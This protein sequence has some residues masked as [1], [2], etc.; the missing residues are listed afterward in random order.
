MDNKKQIARPSNILDMVEHELQLFNL[1]TKKRTREYAQARF[2]YFKLAKKFCKQSSLSAIGRIVNRDH[3]TVINGLKKY[4]TEAMY[5]PYM[6]AVYNKI[7]NKL[8]KNY[9][10]EGK[11][12]I[13]DTTFETILQR[14]DKL[15]EQL[16]K[17]T[18]D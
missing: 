17:I 11:D 15:E 12:L 4:K 8:D 9:I 16:N 7:Y 3:A 10:P 6:D 1:K 14:I 2:I 13:F 5:D 18:N